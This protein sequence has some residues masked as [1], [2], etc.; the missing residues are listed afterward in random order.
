M[1]MLDLIMLLAAIVSA[2]EPENVAALFFRH[3]SEGEGY[4]AVSMCSREALANVTPMLRRL[5]EGIES[6]DRGLLESLER[7]GYSAGPDEMLDWDEEDYLARTLSLPMV[8]SRYSRY[9]TAY[10][11]STAVSDSRCDVFLCLEAPSAAFVRTPVSMIRERGGWRV[12]NFMGMY[13]FP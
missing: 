10:V 9:D 13:S 12:T 6:E 8:S 3:L 2:S 1:V 7:F 5:H 4:Q 11:C